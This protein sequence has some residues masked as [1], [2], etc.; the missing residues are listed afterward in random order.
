MD[1]HLTVLGI[2]RSFLYRRFIIFIDSPQ[3]A[4]TILSCLL[5][6][7]YIQSKSKHRLTFQM[8]SLSFIQVNLGYDISE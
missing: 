7:N 1:T 6:D 8:Y 3:N 4:Y 2:E 5:Y